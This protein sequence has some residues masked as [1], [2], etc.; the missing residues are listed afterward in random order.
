MVLEHHPTLGLMWGFPADKARLLDPAACPLDPARVNAS[1]AACAALAGVDLEPTPVPTFSL[2][3][4]SY[5]GQALAA[6]EEAFRQILAAKKGH[7]PD[8]EGGALF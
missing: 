4:D 6:G 3:P 5:M 7:P 1:V 2:P 8:A